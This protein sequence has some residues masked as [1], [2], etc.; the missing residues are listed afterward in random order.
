MGADAT[1]G[2]DY[3][4]GQLALQDR[5]D[6]RRIADRISERLVHHALTADDKAF[7]EARDMVSSPPSAPT[8][9]R[10]ALLRRL[11]PSLRPAVHVRAPAPAGDPG[12]VVEARRLGV[13][14]AA[15][16]RPGQRSGR[17]AR[18]VA[19]SGGPR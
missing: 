15:R 16:A 18:A 13:R 17:P 14:R 1:T 3:H 19:L 2:I 7:I 10:P 9:S 11:C 12:A 5:F 8:A 6:T 4:P